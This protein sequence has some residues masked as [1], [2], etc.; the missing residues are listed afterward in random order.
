[1]NRNCCRNR[2]CGC[3]NNDN[4]TITMNIYD[5]TPLIDYYELI[6]LINSNSCGCS[7]CSGCG[8]S[9]CGCSDCGCSGC[10]CSD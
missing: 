9:G 10:G 4:N 8:C 2:R 3:N 5:Q 7:G 6:S 1:M